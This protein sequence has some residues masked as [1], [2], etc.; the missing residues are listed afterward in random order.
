M[1]VVDFALKLDMFM[2]PRSYHHLLLG[3]VTFKR[4]SRFGCSFFGGSKLDPEA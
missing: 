3:T 2:S 1:Q 4:C